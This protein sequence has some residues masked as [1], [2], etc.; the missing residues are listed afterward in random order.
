MAGSA[1]IGS[2]RVD[3]GIDT[4]IFDKGLADAMKS[5]KGIGKSM[6]NVGKSMSMYLT[7][8]ILG[9]GALTIKTA[10]DFEASMNR[11]GAATGATG[12]KFQALEDLARELGR[13]TTKSASE[14]ADML[15]MLAKNGLSAEQILGGAAEA[16]IKLSEATGGELSKSADVATN[17]MAQ[18]GKEAKDL[19]P[20]VDQITGVT[21]QSQFGFDDYALALGQAGGVAGSLGVTLTDFNASIAATSDVFN[22]GS[23]AG[24]SFKTFLLRLVPASD[25]AY[26]AMEKLGLEFFDAAGKMK[27]M[28]AIAQELKEGLA[29]LSD[30]AKNDALNT[31]F[32]TD[33]LRTAV[34]LG[35]EGAA[36]INA[37]AEAI[38][39]K[40]IADEQAAARMKGFN[41]EMEKLSGA[42]DELKL[43]IADSGL[44]EA[45]TA[46]VTTVAEWVTSL[47]KTNPE[48]LKWGTIVAGLVAIIGP[49]VLVIGTLVTAIA[50]I[51]VPIAAAVA[52]V[53]ALAAAVVAFWPEIQRAWE[54]FV[55]FNEV[56]LQAGS[57][58]LDTLVAKFNEITAKVAQ[59]VLD[60]AA[61]FAA[62][63]GQMIEIGGQIIDG[64][65]QG[66]Q[67]KWESLKANVTGIAS[68]IK[69]SFTGFFDIHSPSRVMADIGSFIMEGLGLG[70]ASGTPG[71]VAQAGTS[72]KA[73]AAQFSTI[74]EATSGVDPWKG[75]RKVTTGLDG[76]KT[77]IKEVG[78]SASSAFDG[79]GSSIAAAING[80]KEWSDV[81]SDVV[82]KFADIALQGL[83]S[84]FGGGGGSGGLGGLFS[85]LLGGLLGFARGG[86][87]M[88]GGGGGID[89]QIV[90]FRKSPNERVDISKP[91]QSLNS[92][93]GEMQVHVVPSPYFDVRVEEISDGRVAKAVPSIVGQ[94]NR[95]VMPTV[96][97]HQTAKAGGDYRNS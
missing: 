52:G 23:D 2:L 32:G 19:G 43:A 69:E 61:A 31:I 54:I 57:G 47:A 48:I 8:P 33:A 9:F 44:L 28:P 50:A 93:R 11:V 90:A 75:L 22:S 29:G 36:G 16:A 41:G 73:V 89:S 5:L 39:K 72:A 92:G 4:A 14:A 7:A 42:L 17:V 35:N 45:V 15:E 88:P 60:F 20:I 64:L 38:N 78:D 67:A 26:E 95:N 24:T 74:G 65:W 56:L 21:L 81:L 30:E 12:A 76:T 85:G 97:H 96:A 1:V 84:S 86:T 53:A 66:I 58:L 80:T 71:A 79:L 18:F 55:K 91:G 37:M 40:G 62:L 10:G 27:P 63:P 6:Q 70:L 77:A 13:T 51:G 59:F 87:I 68:S 3:L 49:V 83:T 94:A 34:A 25:A 46:F 82:G